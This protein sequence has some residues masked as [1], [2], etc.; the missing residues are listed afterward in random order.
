MDSQRLI[1]LMEESFLRDLIK[2]EE[3]TDI[4]YN[5][6][7][8]FYLHN[9]YGRKQV[10]LPVEKSEISGFIRQIA[11]MAQKQFSYS[12][13]KLD[14]SFGKYRINAIHQSIGKVNNEDS[15]TFSIR[16]GS[17]NLHISPDCDFFPKEVSQL[18]DVLIL[19]NKSIIIGGLTGSGKTEFQKYLLT[20]MPESTRLIIIDNV[21]EL[22]TNISRDDLDINIWQSNEDNPE[23]NIQSLVKNA[24]R[25]NPDWLIVAESRGA[26]MIETLNSALTG[27][28]TIT[29]VHSL[30][31]I[32]LPHRIGRMI[33]MNDKK[34][35]FEDVLSDVF[36]H[37]SIYF[38]L[39]RKID[40]DGIVRRYVKEVVEYQSDGSYTLIYDKNRKNKFDYISNSFLST[41]RI[42]EEFE[43]FKNAFI[44]KEKK[45]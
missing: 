32:S 21:L 26:E 7:S 41:L 35:S 12:V 34:M 23:T 38:F 45:R 2:N 5:G 27:H 39:E 31:A 15:I 25:S 8:F 40:E 10:F 16:I 20:R 29:T 33:M 3:I 24:L 1:K 17:T 6:V 43:E 28:P 37:F 30:N 44:R 18:I 19:S 13:P 22:D 14:V 4:S 36:Y 11:N 42:P 9:L